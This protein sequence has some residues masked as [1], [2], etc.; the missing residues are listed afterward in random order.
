MA[1]EARRSC[2]LYLFTRKPPVS[3]Q[4]RLRDIKAYDINC[5]DHSVHLL[6][7]LQEPFLSESS[8]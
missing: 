5:Q 1:E 4:G 6:G 7:R 3:S 8:L 2:S